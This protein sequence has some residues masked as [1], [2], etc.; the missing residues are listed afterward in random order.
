MNFIQIDADTHFLAGSTSASY[1]PINMRRNHNIANQNVATLIWE[2]SGS[3]DDSN[4]TDSPVA[5]RTLANLSATYTIPTTALRIK[6]IEVKDSSGVYQKLSPVSLTELN[7]S[8]DNYMTGSGMPTQ[9]MLEGNEIRLFTAPGTGSVTMASGMAIRLSRVGT[10]IPVSA[11]TAEPG[12]A[13]PFHRILSYAAAIDFTKDEQQ[14]KFLV[15]Q[16]TRLE[17]GLIRFYSKKNVEYKTAI[18]PANKKVWRN[19][20]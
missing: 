17:N 15:A 2:S 1:S 6:G 19:Y 14:R 5:Y 18:R 10:E 12:F 8:P 16:R 9:Y 11:T 4:N 20:I 13:S 7:V 3:F